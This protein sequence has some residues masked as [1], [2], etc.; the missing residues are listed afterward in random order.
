ML[1]IVGVCR[2]DETARDGCPFEA[3]T[4]YHSPP[5]YHRPVAGGWHRQRFWSTSDITRGCLS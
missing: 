5:S 1:N 3:G 2:A 4:I